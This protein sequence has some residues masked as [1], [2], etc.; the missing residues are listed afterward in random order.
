MPLFEDGILADI[1]KKGNKKWTRNEINFKW[2]RKY[3]L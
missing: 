3:L 2:M 1:L